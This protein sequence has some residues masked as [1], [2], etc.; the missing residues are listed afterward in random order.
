MAH[1]AH[2]LDVG[3]DLVPHTASDPAVICN[4]VK[5]LHVAVAADYLRLRDLGLSSGVAEREVADN[6]DAGVGT[7][8]QLARNGHRR[9]IYAHGLAV[10]IYTFLNVLPD[11]ILSEFGLQD[12]LIDVAA[13]LGGCHFACFLFRLHFSFRNA[14]A[15]LSFLI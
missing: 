14:E 10:I 11:V 6:A 12:G 13:K 2:S 7:L 9:G 8:A 15:L 4:D 5:I 1:V 3:L